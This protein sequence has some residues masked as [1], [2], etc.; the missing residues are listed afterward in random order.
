M[1]RK[2][3][4]LIACLSLVMAA[5]SGLAVSPEEQAEIDAAAS[6]PPRPAIGEP[7]PHPGAWD[8]PEAIVYFSDFEANNGGLAPSLDWEWGTFAWAGTGQCSGSAAPPAASYSGTNMWGTVLN[9][10]Y[11]NLGNNTGYDT[12]VNGNTADDSKLSLF[13]DL[14]GYTDAQL[15]WWEWNDLYLNWDWGEVYVNGTAV[16]QHC[17]TGYTAP[18]A[19]VQQVVDLTPYVGGYVTIDFHMMSST[20]VAYSGWY[21]DDLEVQGTPV[22]VE[23][24]SFSIE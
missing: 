20:V 18:S 2:A 7:I 14:A 19:W 1:E 6:T 17:G 3:L 12:C 13:I 15:S 21:I 22:P 8:N 24:Q 11:N 4:I 5:S 16:F 23:L 9:D 10:C